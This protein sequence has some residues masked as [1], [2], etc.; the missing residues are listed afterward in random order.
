MSL[1][2]IPRTPSRDQASR[3]QA[4]ATVA[5]RLL[6]ALESLVERHRAAALH[7]E[8]APLHPELIAAE[9]AHQ[10]AAARRDLL[11]HPPPAA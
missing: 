9:V 3:D 6:T 8:P 1:S 4:R 7:A 10:L 2:H 5:D 11:R